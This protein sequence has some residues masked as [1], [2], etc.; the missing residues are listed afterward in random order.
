MYKSLQ[1]NEMD[2]WVWRECQIQLALDSVAAP[3]S[4]L[5]FLTPTNIK[6]ALDTQLQSTSLR[7]AEEQIDRLSVPSF[8]DVCNEGMYFLVF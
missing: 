3:G 2:P 8:T 7:D 5:D 1:N 6:K 4:V